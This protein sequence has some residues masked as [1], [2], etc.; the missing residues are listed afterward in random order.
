MDVYMRHLLAPTYYVVLIHPTSALSKSYTLVRTTCDP[1]QTVANLN[2][3][4]AGPLLYRLR[5]GC[6]FHSLREARAAKEYLATKKRSFDSKKKYLMKLADTQGLPYYSD[7]I[8]PP[9]G[10]RAYLE[11]YA[12]TRYV[13]TY[14]RLIQKK[15]KRRV[16][17]ETCVNI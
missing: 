5:A 2:P 10:T 3:A 8:V 9:G 17:H 4:H 13:R 7:E 14:D 15:R 6:A 12:P 1:L 11:R 16:P